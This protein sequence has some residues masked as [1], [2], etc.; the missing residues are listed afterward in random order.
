MTTKSWWRQWLSR[1]RSSAQAHKPRL[2]TRR[3]FLEPLE[4]RTL[5]DAGALVN[6]APS[7]VA[8]APTLP[9]INE[10]VK[11]S[12]GATV[13][14]LLGASVT[15][16]DA[17]AKKG[18]AVWNLSGAG[19][20]QY[21]LNGGMTWAKFGTVSIA[22]AKLLRDTDRVRFIPAAN[23]NGSADFSFFAW[24]RTTG[25][26]GTNADTSARGGATSFSSVADTASSTVN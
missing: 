10:D 19:T 25:A 12:T 15:D 8:H 3:P 14:S 11:A 5:L 16:P 7:M 20:W 17:G 9:A 13:A 21:S 4:D 24:D 23:A 1:S 26:A 6:T 18:I 22:S 2:Q